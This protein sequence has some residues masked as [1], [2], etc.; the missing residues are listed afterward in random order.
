MAI[1]AQNMLAET[2]TLLTCT[3]A[4]RSSKFRRDADY[5]AEGFFGIPQVSQANSATRIQIKSLIS[6]STSFQIH[7]SLI[8]S[9]LS[10]GIIS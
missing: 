10:Q 6:P 2:I 3:G 9:T 5:L 4:D 8:T 1:A 7:Y